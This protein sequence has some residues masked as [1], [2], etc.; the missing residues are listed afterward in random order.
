MFRSPPTGNGEPEQGRRSWKVNDGVESGCRMAWRTHE[1]AE[2]AGPGFS[3]APIGG[4]T[5]FKKA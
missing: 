4:K 1:E 5:K 3:V 2:A